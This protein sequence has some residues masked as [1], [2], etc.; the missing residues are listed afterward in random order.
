MKVFQE[1]MIVHIFMRKATN[2]VISSM[3][4]YLSWFFT[5]K[6]FKLGIFEDKLVFIFGIIC[7]DDVNLYKSV[8]GL[9]PIHVLLLH[10]FLSLKPKKSSVPHF[11]NTS[12]SQFWRNRPLVFVCF[13]FDKNENNCLLI[14]IE[15][16]INLLT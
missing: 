1:L 16:V 11:F 5:L 3:Y 4:D 7:T 10:L 6:F 15:F 13:Y 8:T 12:P 9:I 2:F 14:I